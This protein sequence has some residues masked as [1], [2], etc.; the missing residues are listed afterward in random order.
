MYPVTPLHA[1]ITD[2]GRAMFSTAPRTSA[3]R[4]T[5]RLRVLTHTCE[6]SM[7]M[8]ALL[9]AAGLLFAILLERADARAGAA[10]EHPQREA[11]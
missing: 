9:G 11:A 6:A 7:V 1:T 2:F 3:S 4:L 5:G 10:L 8:L